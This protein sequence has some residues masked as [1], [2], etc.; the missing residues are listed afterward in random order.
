MRITEIFFSV[1]G[2]SSHVGKPCVFVRLTGCSLRCVWCDTKYSYSGGTEM[3]LADVLA[4]VAKH[5]TR[6][7]EITGGEPLEQDEAYSLMD[8]LLARDYTVMLETGGH[9]RIDRVPEPVIKIIDIKCP[10]SGEGHTFCWENIALAAT[11]DEFKF[12][13]ASRKDYEWSRGVVRNQLR[14]RPNT[15]L[16]SPA[17]EELPPRQLAEWVLADGLPVRMQ[18]QIHKYIWGANARGV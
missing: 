16:F 7:V 4:V 3:P 1:Q 18:L 14:D 17:H 8:S 5:P 9:V 13:I 10:D 11:Q 6:L 12:V 15:I 2:E